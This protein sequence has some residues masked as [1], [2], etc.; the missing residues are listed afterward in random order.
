MI[1][2]R[3]WHDLFCQRMLQ[4]VFYVQLIL[5]QSYGGSKFSM[6]CECGRR[7]KDPETERHCQASAKIEGGGRMN[8]NLGDFHWKLQP[9][10]QQTYSSDADTRIVGGCRAGH[11]PWYV[12]ILHDY[13]RARCGGA[14]I[15][16][17]WILSAAH[18][19]CMENKKVNLPCK[20]IGYKKEERPWKVVPDYDFS[21][22]QVSDRSIQPFRPQS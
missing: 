8:L 3:T 5:S 20:R 9:R 11:I 2:H 10:F 18:C 14:L 12:L 21:D 7:Q 19:F 16:K 22:I 13:P 4:Y 1:F 17:F 15:N 6:G